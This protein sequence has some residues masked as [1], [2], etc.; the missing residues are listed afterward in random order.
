MFALP[1]HTILLLTRLL[2]FRSMYRVWLI[3]KATLHSMMWGGLQIRTMSLFSGDHSYGRDDQT[4]LATLVARICIIFWLIKVGG[5]HNILLLLMMSFATGYQCT[6]YTV[7]PFTDK[8]VQVRG[9]GTRCRK[10]NQLHS[11]TRIGVEHVFGNLKGRFPGLRSI[12]GHDISR[13]YLAVEALIILHN[14][15]LQ[16]GDYAEEISDFVHETAEDLDAQ[17]AQQENNPWPEDDDEIGMEIRRL[18]RQSMGL[19]THA[20]LKADGLALRE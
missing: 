4:F 17:E 1:L 2:L 18:G 20:S 16:I 14:F 11:R 3:T 9:Q 13:V 19:E 8:E 6:P 10:F 5:S 15:F 12:G 7:R